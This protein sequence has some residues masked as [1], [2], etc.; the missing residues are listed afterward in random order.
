M[1]CLESREPLS[2]DAITGPGPVEAIDQ[3]Q[4]RGQ[5][6]MRRVEGPALNKLE[7]EA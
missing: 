3:N 4:D 2:D 6:S 1:A 7:A 5:A